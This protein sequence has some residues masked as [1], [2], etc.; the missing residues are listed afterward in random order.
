[1]MTHWKVK[2]LTTVNTV[3][4]EGLKDGKLRTDEI[5]YTKKDKK[6]SFK[7]IQ[8]TEVVKKAK[9]LN[10]ISTEGRFFICLSRLSF[11]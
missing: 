5:K 10:S 4:P 7:I 11:S 9:T 1:M 2:I 8:Q 3:S 6:P